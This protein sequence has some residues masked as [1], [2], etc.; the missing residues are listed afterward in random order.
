MRVNWRTLRVELE[1]AGNLG[2]LR[3]LDDTIASDERDDPGFYEGVTSAQLQRKALANFGYAFEFKY[4]FLKDKFHIGFDQG[5]A[6]GDTAVPPWS[7]DVGGAIGV[8]DDNNLISNLPLVGP[9]LSP[10]WY[11][12]LYAGGTFVA[13][14]TLMHVSRGTCSELPFRWNCPPEISKIILRC[15][16][17]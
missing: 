12:V 11:G 14:P 16:A 15:A 7:P 4:G 10:S 3:L 6:T 2:T 5:M 9:V 17:C 1:A 13:G 8:N